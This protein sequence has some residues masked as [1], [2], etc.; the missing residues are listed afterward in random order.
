MEKR[1]ENGEMVVIKEG[2][3]PRRTRPM[4]GSKNRVSFLVMCMNLCVSAPRLYAH[5]HHKRHKSIG[6]KGPCVAPLLL[7]EGVHKK[8]H[9]KQKKKEASAG[10]D[11]VS[12]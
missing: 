3:V 7:Y 2:C 9:N 11:C 10:G 6:K 4:P 12:L 8:R 1:R 5:D